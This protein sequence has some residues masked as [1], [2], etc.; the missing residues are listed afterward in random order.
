MQRADPD[1]VEHHV[2]ID[3]HA[4][5][6]QHERAVFQNHPTAERIRRVRLARVCRGLRFRK[7]AGADGAAVGNDAKVDGR[8][9]GGA[10]RNRV[11]NTRKR[12]FLPNAV[13]DEVMRGHRAGRP[14]QFAAGKAFLR[15]IPS[16]PNVVRGNACGFARL[17]RGIARQR[18]FVEHARRAQ[19]YVEIENRQVI[20]VAR[21]A[22]I[23]RVN[24][25]KR[26]ASN[27]RGRCLPRAVGVGVVIRCGK[28][29]KSVVDTEAAD[30]VTIC[31]HIGRAGPAQIEILANMVE[32]FA[33]NVLIGVLRI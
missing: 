14:V 26:N 33:R 20:A 3:L 5:V 9:A 12:R 24:A 22:D 15:G 6:K 19:L 4:R 31:S 11:R 10:K 21:V 32:G 17:R 30:V 13:Y 28:A 2:L 18:H 8:A 7:R 16:R 23:Q 27:A 29:F 25:A 1:R